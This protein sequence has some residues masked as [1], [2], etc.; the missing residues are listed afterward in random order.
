MKIIFT[1]LTFIPCFCFGQWTQLGANINGSQASDK[2]GN[3]NSIAIDSIGNTMAVG[4]AFNSNVFPYSGYAQVL[5]WDL[6][7]KLR[8]T[9]KELKPLKSIYYPDFI[10]ANQNH[11]ADNLKEGIDKNEHLLA[12]RGDIR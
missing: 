11:R 7:E 12:I 8:D 10:A 6:Q 5:D 3:T 4:S 2:L 1:L 9:M